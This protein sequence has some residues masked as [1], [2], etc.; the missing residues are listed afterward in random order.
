MSKK[1]VT[2]AE[3]MRQRTA[4]AERKERMLQ[5]SE[6]EKKEKE[7]EEL[8][9][10]MK[11]RADEYYPQCLKK[12][13]E[14]ADAA[15]KVARYNLLAYGDEALPDHIKF[16]AQHLSKLLIAD[17]L[18]VETKYDKVEPH[19]SDPMSRRTVYSTWLEISW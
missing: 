1:S 16:L 12:V 5:L 6:C 10:T 9:A 17:G 2:L 18:A 13:E 8:D 15:K 7:K 19:G 11:V 14:A 3:E 4:A